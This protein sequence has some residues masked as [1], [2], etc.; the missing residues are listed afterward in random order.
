MSS[1]QVKQTL[2][3]HSLIVHTKQ[4]RLDTFA[5]KS[6]YYEIFLLTFQETVQPTRSAAMQL[7]NVLCIKSK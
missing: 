5:A 4:T 1:V 6:I 7:M 2:Y 3:F